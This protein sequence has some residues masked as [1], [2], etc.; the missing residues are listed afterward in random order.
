MVLAGAVYGKVNVYVPADG[1]VK[2]VE[3]AAAVADVADG[4]GAETKVFVY[5][6]HLVPAGP[7]VHSVTGNG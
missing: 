6:T 7:A 5:S 1:A 4:A 2:L 3:Q